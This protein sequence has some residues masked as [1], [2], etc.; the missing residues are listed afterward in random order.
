[1]DCEDEDRDGFAVTSGRRSMVSSK[2][3]ENDV[4]VSPP[5]SIH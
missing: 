3:S 1:M 4:L 2:E 5:D